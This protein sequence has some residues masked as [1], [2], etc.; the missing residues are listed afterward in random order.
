MITQP[1]PLTAAVSGTGISCNGGSN[2]TAT[3]TANGGTIPYSYL[4]NT[5]PVQTTAT[6]T[7]LAAGTYIITITDSQGCTVSSSLTITEAS[8]LISGISSQVNVSCFG[9]NNGSAM[10]TVTGGTPSYSYL[11][12]N[13]QITNPAITLVAGTYTVTVTDSFGC[14]TSTEVIITEPPLLT[15]NASGTHVSCNG[16]DNGTAT[17]T[18]TGGT[19]S[20]NY[21]WSDGQ[22]TNPAAGL[23]A[24]TYT[25]TVTDSHGC[26][27]SASFTVTEP[28]VLTSVIASQT[29]VSCFGLSDGMALVIAGGGTPGYTYLWSNGQIT[30]PAINLVAGTYTVAVTDSHNCTDTASVVITEPFLLTAVVSE[31]DVSC[32]GGSN[33]TATVTANGGTIPYSY[34]WSTIP[35]QT[36]STATGLVAGNYLVNVTDNH[37]C[38]ISA[39]LTVT[40]PSLLIGGI[41]SQVNVNCNGE[42]NGSATVTVIGGTPSYS[43]L[44]S[45]G[46]VINPAINLS[47]GIYTVTVTDA[48]LCSLTASVTITQ[49]LLLSAIISAQTNINCN[50]GNNGSATVI[51]S[52]G[53][54]LYS[55]TWNTIPVQHTSTATSLSAGI[56]AVTVTDA[57]LCTTSASVLLTEPAILVLG[58]SSQTNLVCNGGNNG[59]ATVTCSGGTI[60]YSYAW[61]TVPV[62]T[63][64]I[65]LNLVAGIYTVTVTDAHACTSTASVTITEPSLLIAG[66][67]S[68][69][70]V[71]CFGGNNGSATVSVSGGIIP[72]LYSWNTLPVQT[73]ATASNLLAGIYTVVVTDMNLCTTAVSVTITQPAASL[74]ATIIAQTNVICY[75]YSN[76]SATIFVTGGTPAYSYLWNT[77]PA[78]T[79]PTVTNLTAG[80]YTVTITDA[81]LCTTTTSVTISQPPQ[82]LVSAGPDAS[83]CETQSYALVF[84]TASN[85]SSL[86][87]T[88][89]GDGTFSNPTILN[90]L[91]T[92]GTND[93]T[94]GSVKLVL[95]A[96]GI[97]PCP[98]SSD[99]M[100][101]SISRQAI[102][103]AGPDAIMCE[104]QGSYL[105]SNATSSHYTSLSWTT[106]GTGSF[107]NASSLN[108]IYT[109]SLADIAAGSV[110]LTLTA[111]SAAPC[112]PV[113]DAMTL[114]IS[115]QSI[116]YA[117]PDDTICET[118]PS[119]SLFAATSTY[120][121]SLLWTTSGT[122]TFSNSSTADPV[123]FPSAQ[124]ILAG[125][126]ILKLTAQSTSPCIA[127]VDSMSLKI[128]KQAI[129]YAGP[130]D[131][132]C[133]T[134]G[135]L[136]LS[137]AT[138]VNYTS[139]LWTSSGT[140]TFNNPSSVNP[141]YTPSLADITN[142]AVVLTITA[143]SAAPCINVMDGMTLTIH[144]QAIVN[145]GP[146]ALIC[147]SQGS[148]ALASAS[149]NYYTSVLWTTSGSGTFS[150]PNI[151]NA[152]YFPSATDISSGSVNLTIT[153]MGITPCMNVNDMMILHI[154]R[155]ATAFAGPDDT[156]CATQASYHLLTAVAT[157]YTSLLWT[158]SGTGT[159]NNPTVQNP[160]YIPS[161]QDTI[162]GSV[163]LTL[164]ATS[165]APCITA[166]DAMTLR[167]FHRVTASAG[168][169]A[170]SL[171]QLT[172]YTVTGAS[173]SNYSTL[174]W[175][176]NGLG[177]L[178]NAT[179]I[180]PSY[181]PSANETGTVILTLRAYS[182]SPCTESV[183]DQMMLTIY[184]LPSGTLALNGNSA[185]CRGDSTI[186]RFDFTGTPPWTLTYS[187]GTNLITI[188]N[189][190]TSPYNIRVFPTVTTLYTYTALADAHCSALPSMIHDS[191]LVTVNPLPDVEFTWNL[192]PQN[193]EVQFHIDSAVTDLGAIGYMCLWN[194]GD[195]TFGYGHNPIHIYP[196]SY[197]YTYN[198][199]LT[200]T[201]TLGCSNS[202][203]HQV[204]VPI[205]P[206]AFF[207][208][209]SPVCLGQQMCFTDLSFISA[210]PFQWIKEW[211][212]DFGDGSPNDTIHFPNNPNI[213]HTYITVGTFPV[214]LEVIDN[215]GD[216][217][218]YTSNVVIL[219]N[220]IAD[221]QASTACQN[222]LVTFNN[223]S[224]L[225]GGESIM[226]WDWNFGDPGS[227]IHNTSDLENPTHMF[228]FGDSI[229][230]VRLVIVNFAGCR[231]TII[232]PVYVF[233]AP[234]VDFT[235]D[236]ACLSQVVTFT[237]NTLI[238]H[239]DSIANWS[240]DFGDGTSPST[241]PVTSSHIYTIPGVH[242]VTLTV[243]DL[244]GCQNAVT[245]SVDVNPLPFANFTW[246]T[247]VCQT[248]AV[249][250]TDQSSI[251]TGFNGYLAKWQ[252][253]F[254]DGTPVQTIVIPGSPNV[255]HTFAGIALNHLVHLT[256]WTGDS[257]SAYVEQI[258]TSLP[259]PIAN[260]QVSPTTCKDQP[261]QFTDFS[262]PNGGVS[263]TSWSWNFDDAA[264]GADNTSTLQN[265][266]HMFTNGNSTYN[267]SLI[268]V[269]ANTCRDTTIKPIFIHALPPVDFAYDTACLNQAVHFNGNSG[270]T[271]IDSI[272]SWLWDFGDG[273]PPVTDPINTSHQYSISGT[274]ITA[275]TVTDHHGCNNII[276]HTVNVNPLPI[277]NFTWNAP[278]CTGTIVHFTD[279]SSVISG[280]LSRWQ[281]DFGDGSPIQTIVLPASPN[282]SH[283]FSGTA[284]NHVVRLTVWTNDSCNSYIEKTVSSIPAPAADFHFPAIT[285]TSHS[286]KFTDNSHT[287]GGG[288]IIQ[289]NW[290]FGD[291][292]SGSSN[293]STL[294]NPNHT[295]ANS[296]TY[297]VTLVVSNASTCSDTI[298]KSV[299]IHLLP[300]AR[301]HADTACFGIP[302]QFT[303]L[304]VPNA[305][306]IISYSWDFGDGT[307]PGI[308]PNPAHTYAYPGLFTVTLTVINSNGCNKDTSMQVIVNPLPL[309]AFTFSSPTCVGATVNYI[310]LS[311][312][313]PGYTGSIV[314]WVWDFG[315]GTPPITILYPVSPDIPH[316]FAGPALAHTVRLTVT[317][318][319]SCSA[320]IE[321]TVNSTPVPV[322]NFSFPSTN[323]AA[324]TIKFTDQSLPNGGGT[325]ITWF[326]NFGD[327][328]SGTLN[329]STSQN[330]S[331]TFLGAGTYNVSLI[332]SNAS[333]C[334]NTA[335]KPITINPLPL[336]NFHADT[337][338]LGTL[339][340]FTD[341]SSTNS[342]MIT[343][344]YWQFGDGQISTVQ[345]PTHLYATASVFTA[346]LR[347][348]TNEGCY[349]D[350]T[351]QVMVIPTPFAAFSFSAPT[352]AVTDSVHF[353]DQSSASSG[354]IVKW[355]WDFGDG[356]FTTI[357]PPANPDVYHIYSSAGTYNVILTVNTSDSC[358]GQKINTVTIQS[359]PLPAFS[360]SINRCE[361]MPV[362]FTDLSQSNGGGAIVAW[363]WNFGDPG[364]GSANTSTIRDP[365]HSFSHAGTFHVNLTV[366]NLN[367]CHDSITKSVLVNKAPLANFNADTACFG[368]P[369]HFIDSSVPNS[370]TIIAW[371]WNFGD[372][373]S[374][375]NN[376]S[377][378][379][380]PTHIF[381]GTGNYNVT[382]SVINS[383]TC[384][385]DT[386]IQVLVNP[387]PLALFEY[388]GSCVNTPTQFTDL[389][390]APGSQIISWF[391]DFGDG[392][393]TSTI[394]NPTYI[395]TISGNYN[396][397]LKVTNLNNCADSIILPV[398]SNPQPVA[399]FIYT[400]FFCPAG[401]VN[402]QD[403]STASGAHITGRL[404]IFE[405]GYTSNLENPVYKFGVTDTTYAVTLIITDNIG[406]MD[407][408]V[409]SVHVK[410]GL[411][412]TFTNDTVCYRN[413]T[414]FT[415]V[416]QAKG[417][418]LYGVV[419]NFGDPNSGANNISH[420]YY[421][422]HKFTQ[423]ATYFVKMKA[424]DSNNCVDSILK[425]VSVFA[426][427]KPSFSYHTLPCESVIYFNDS[428]VAGSGTIASWEWNFGDGSTSLIINGPETGNT[429]HL[430]VNPGFYKVILKVTNSNGC[431][432]TVS[433]I[434]HRIPCLTASFGLP[435]K[436]LCAHYPVAFADS[437]LPRA[438]ISRWQWNWGDRTDTSYNVPAPVVH[439]RFSDGGTYK[440]TLIITTLGNG[441]PVS[442]ST[443]QMVTIHPTPDVYFSNSPVCLNQINL[444]RD[445]SVTFGVQSVAWNWN[446]GD[447][448]SDP[449]NTS[450]LKNPV[451]EYHSPGSF[452]VKLVMVNTF[453]CKDSLIKPTRVFANPV[454]KFSN[455]I[456]C[457]GDPTKFYDRS[458]PGDTI[459]GYWHWTF[460]DA[461]SKKDTSL[462]QN[463]VFRYKKAGNYIVKL[464]VRDLNGCS[465]TA[466]S[467]ITVNV[468]PLSAFT[469]TENFEGRNGVIQLNNQSSGAD[470]YS[471]DFGN[472]QTSTDENPVA[473]YSL[474][475]SYMISLVST[476]RYNC[477]D[478]TFY[479]YELI[480]HGL[481]IPNAF[482]PTNPSSPVRLFKPVGINLKD[483][484]IMVFDNWGH[485][486]WESTKIDVHGSPE[487]GWDGYYKGALMPEGVY[488][489]KIN[490]TFMDNSIWKG[491]DI[492][493]GEAKTIG[494]VTLIR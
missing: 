198:V 258:V 494:T 298:V 326:W 79:S 463:P 460:G 456:A 431:F 375:T 74:Q 244:H 83:I 444:F 58:I 420:Q 220:P 210:P 467:T 148:Y 175:T 391:W 483:Y 234:T 367:G 378:L 38:T 295:F 158:T 182:I 433:R 104:S 136:L 340:S 288:D 76:G 77:L 82:I 213:C 95:T 382:L 61:N 357:T 437:S 179:T 227:G 325:I 236:T 440:V 353:T 449:N 304:S 454:A 362:Q 303:D 240:W 122:G 27:V 78:Q 29:N 350:T 392:V 225:N 278:V 352:C 279:Q 345:N 248:L 307:S 96:Y 331:H 477:S 294:R 355:I 181:T 364:T 164:S 243:T 405:P 414:H 442:D 34:L 88:T 200:V 118:Q 416:N 147:E 422:T 51:A 373:A 188:N 36:A 372:P 165:I 261:V 129:V 223:T 42:N 404:W 434:V 44:W 215:N 59:N 75:G 202:V 70:N 133:E 8:L 313:P 30:D 22:V 320:F 314:K 11:W 231:D 432:D 263:I 425:E 67:Q 108:P 435:D 216:S 185:I 230:N 171:C 222:M 217:D 80:I 119:Y 156:I 385:H 31:T 409:D 484:H 207:S 203:T 311:I 160:T 396:V 284:L 312:I 174:L 103:S 92:L 192:G 246:N 18:A 238:T 99:T 41:S 472:G 176:D 180:H 251:P 146:D 379:Q 178:T 336:A 25:V 464:L 255:L 134:Q 33:G 475:G 152:V 415:P 168:P 421:A 46:Q 190:T 297:N 328:S 125:Q 489:W 3:V 2:G 436:L 239:I 62:Q 211:I 72:Y 12:S 65:A 318:S 492:G 28:T 256:V 20:Y 285:C 395:Y 346:S 419:W 388:S 169:D 184:P 100:I 356:Q 43:Y 418:S 366:T 235:H 348:T 155:Q 117:G 338:C 226:S 398:V 1:L 249:Q 343:Q 19:P 490:A 260:F 7:G 427:P 450:S 360:Y 330:P 126:V 429:S 98:D 377:T 407:T 191:I 403:Q 324:Q 354:T 482:S 206:V 54:V 161:A 137:L 66:L 37:G 339:T 112:I 468:T 359:A 459:E 204:F 259:A 13:G 394:Q 289:W 487:Q 347:V 376:T 293:T 399:A 73:N 177:T 474:D 280:Y 358:T 142:G 363:A 282:I 315:D 316:I 327:S 68:L 9:G 45:D 162:N 344:Y 10:V 163:I 102:A 481:Y 24:G 319:D 443:T 35:V 452:D 417:D 301:F 334:S 286:V 32:N 306:G 488:M 479:K 97:P 387:K 302:T 381:T 272:V 455:S 254:G 262:L 140:G 219:P 247:P 170:S 124:D 428:T 183:I 56:Y 397:K 205:A 208:S 406:C 291:P 186:L 110:T 49:P 144:R 55:Y 195:G 87:W 139:I 374:G 386:I 265:P 149:A 166:T 458:K 199:T 23:I 201:D 453:G 283:I 229:Y 224:L 241:N 424:W 21:L 309:P 111:G 86:G 40:E 157:Y 106:S 130:D 113:S 53:T 15:A 300:V 337:V 401:Q 322:A 390:V 4:W 264:S 69:T 478:T 485:L 6:A 268:V 114:N 445:T 154:S 101:L 342:G 361:L 193:Y 408:V 145:A 486:M 430:Y 410:P 196:S 476:N 389:S 491:S 131:T 413:I 369:T 194:F 94:A 446:F 411:R 462:F 371:N 47:A 141:V 105:I 218:D 214:T 143:T 273:T 123:Y 84:A 351:K 323:C 305:S 93:I 423:P 57:H 5:I 271:Q 109:P 457:S 383:G 308:Q 402:F 167:I 292:G 17:V 329:N 269:N 209:N 393:G 341:L 426:L 71:N 448:G 321:H 14:S 115:R 465:D 469:L 138:A 384:L 173:A 116:V 250:F 242:N 310:N 16:G 365:L 333:G 128:N 232:K 281:W 412:F 237:A 349:K 466:D 90:P 60:P 50:G 212:W 252:W 233:P 91:Y 253:D 132:I 473:T 107:N 120:Y 48:H 287:N 153:A 480:F 332:V 368:I 438:S 26:T 257:C 197:S 150:N 400:S 439:H 274:F 64:N 441:I 127:S 267:V 172:P 447:P 276:S 296:G 270:I 335:Q 451:H 81:H 299:T 275:L 159:F 187:D 85:Y 290:N 370:G 317:T 151:V 493:K 266:S 470:S 39:S 277:A 121:T 89:L 461:S 135:T 221:F 63:T 380:N 471:W 52:G 245:H 189:I 228:S